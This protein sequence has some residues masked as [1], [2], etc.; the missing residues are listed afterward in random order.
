MVPH[1]C[2]SCG[3]SKEWGLGPIPSSMH[4]GNSSCRDDRSCAVSATGIS[5]SPDP[6]GQPREA[7]EDGVTWNHRMIPFLPHMR[8]TKKLMFNFGMMPCLPEEWKRLDSRVR[9]LSFSQWRGKGKTPTHPQLG[10]MPAKGSCQ[11]L[12]P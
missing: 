1:C 3:E 6:H 7:L 4:G 8:S 5:S 11:V 10:K 9:T 12:V 2:I